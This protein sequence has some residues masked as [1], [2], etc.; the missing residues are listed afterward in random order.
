MKIPTYRVDYTDED[1]EI[2]TI[3]IETINIIYSYSHVVFL[4]EHGEEG[5]TF[6]R[7]DIVSIILL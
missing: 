5:Y 6:L 3:D 2:I 7:K 4:D 1:G